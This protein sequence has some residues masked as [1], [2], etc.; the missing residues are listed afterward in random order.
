MHHLLQRWPRRGQDWRQYGCQVAGGSPPACMPGLRPLLRGRQGARGE[1]QHAW[2]KAYNPRRGGGIEERE[3]E[4]H[5]GGGLFDCLGC[6]ITSLLPPPPLLGGGGA[7]SQGGA[8]VRLY[9]RRGP[10]T[11]GVSSELMTYS[12]SCETTVDQIWLPMELPTVYFVD[13]LRL[14]CAYT[15]EHFVARSTQGFLTE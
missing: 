13:V 1:F 4:V 8:R 7:V 15:E 6:W 3:E 12:Q 14:F 5:A 10:H 9:R 2:P 11:M